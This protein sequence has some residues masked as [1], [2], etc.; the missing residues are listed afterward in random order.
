MTPVAFDPGQ[1]S[2][3]PTSHPVTAAP[4]GG[5]GGTA[6]SPLSPSLCHQ[7]RW[8][9]CGP[10]ICPQGVCVILGLPEP[11]VSAE[12]ELSMGLDSGLQT[13]NLPLAR[14]KGRGSPGDN[15][16]ELLPCGAGLRFCCQHPGEG[17]GNKVE[18]SWLP[19]LGRADRNLQAGRCLLSRQQWQQPPSY[20]DNHTWPPS[21]C[22]QEGPAPTLTTQGHPGL[23]KVENGEEL[24]RR[25]AEGPWAHLPFGQQLNLSFG[26]D[27][28]LKGGTGLSLSLQH[29]PQAAASR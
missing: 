20:Y 8:P 18:W 29:P 28:G 25:Q 22:P 1:E 16:P 17:A 6:A 12:S 10:R 4:P 13:P 21:L 24:R 5:A 3:V 9:C 2:A 19:S 23:P 14:K 7:A 27:I 11:L 26:L 15:L